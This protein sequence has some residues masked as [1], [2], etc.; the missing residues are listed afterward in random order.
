MVY[1]LGCLVVANPCLV[2]PVL[3]DFISV[4]FY[5][6]SKPELFAKSTT[7]K[8]ALLSMRKVVKEFTYFSDDTIFQKSISSQPKSSNY[9]Q[10]RKIAHSAYT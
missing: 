3:S 2:A 5:I 9:L 4:L 1:Q 10:L 7:V 8:Y 6:I